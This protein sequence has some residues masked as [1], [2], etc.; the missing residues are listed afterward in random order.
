MPLL[1]T[2]IA[3]GSGAYMVHNSALWFIPC[4]FAVELMYFAIC[5]VSEPVTLLIC[6]GIAG[7]GCVMKEMYGDS[8][9][10]FLPWNLDA[11]F[12]AL[13]F[14]GVSNFIMK[15]MSHQRIQSWIVANRTWSAVGTA[16]LFGGMALLALRYGICSMGSSSYQCP[17]WCF[18]LRAFLGCFAMVAL[19]CLLCAIPDI[20]RIKRGLVWCGKNSMDIMCLHI[21]IKGVAIILI[22]WLLNVSCDVSS[23]PYLS[24]VAFVITM[25]VIV[26]VVTV[27]N[28]FIR[29]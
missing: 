12:F 1:Q 21:P 10:H 16:L 18:F 9:L 5:R 17:L 22:A 29:K 7:L 24:S 2:F 14:Y 11:A 19:S 8:Y 28:R 20:G 6:F 25:V 3:Q 13:P 23:S 15:Y 26:P 4:L 27:I